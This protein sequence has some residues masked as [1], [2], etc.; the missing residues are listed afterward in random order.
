MAPTS[1]LDIAA[2][3]PAANRVSLLMGLGDGS[4]AERQDVVLGA[5]PRGLVAGKFNADDRL[6]LMVSQDGSAPL[7]LLTTTCLP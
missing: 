4:L 2:T 5:M 3:I 6:E 7:K 1:Q